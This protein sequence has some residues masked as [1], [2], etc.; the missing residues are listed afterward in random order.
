MVSEKGLEYI[1]KLSHA[2]MKIKLDADNEFGSGNLPF[3]SGQVGIDS[4]ILRQ[5]QPAN[6]AFNSLTAELF[7]DGRAK[8]YIPV[9]YLP[10]LD[11]IENKIRNL[12][13]LQVQN[14]L[15]EIMMSDN[16][17]LLLHLDFF[18]INQLLLITMNLL[19][20]YEACYG[21][22]AQE[23]NLR[24]VITLE[25]VWRLVPFCDLDAWGS[26]VQKFGL[27]VRN[28]RFIKIPFLKKKGLP[29][30]YPLWKTACLLIAEGFGLPFEL[31]AK[32]LFSNQTVDDAIP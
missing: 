22:E 9:R 6:V 20:F 16:D 25:K 5:V 23:A 12:K 21:D 18:D 11:D 8:F 17:D 14:V 27:P 4:V 15:K 30:N 13:S 28:V 32:I 19:T 29:V 31:Y 24:M 7:L 3:T 1:L 2:R 10:I 26:H